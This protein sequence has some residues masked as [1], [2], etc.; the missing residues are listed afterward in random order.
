MFSWVQL[1]YWGTVGKGGR[2]C[3]WECQASFTHLLLQLCVC[4]FEAEKERECT[5]VCACVRLW[6]MGERV[7]ECKCVCAYFLV[8]K[9]KNYDHLLL[10]RPSQMCS[11]WNNRKIDGNALIETQS[12]KNDKIGLNN[13]TQTR[14]TS[15]STPTPMT[16]SMI[17]SA[18]ASGSNLNRAQNQNPPVRDFSRFFYFF[19]FFIP[20]AN[21]MSQKLRVNFLL[22]EFRWTWI[23]SFP[24]FL[25]ESNFCSTSE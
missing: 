11:M 14:P 2:G 4:V 19:F 17:I 7:C 16:T 8:W 23:E 12:V 9:P 18:M 25:P 3:F 1:K 20:G 10:R 24:L 13:V 15:P 6:H 21:F 22:V 5:C